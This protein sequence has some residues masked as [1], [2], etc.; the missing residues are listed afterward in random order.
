MYTEKSNFYTESV[1]EIKEEIQDKEEE[2]GKNKSEKK[3]KKEESTKADNKPKK[4]D[5]PK[6]EKSDN[7]TTETPEAKKERKLE[8]KEVKLNEFESLFK[9][10]SGTIVLVCKSCEADDK[11]KVSLYTY[12]Y[13]DSSKSYTKF[14]SFETTPIAEKLGDENLKI[15]PSAAAVNPI[16]KD[17]YILNSTGLQF[18]MIL[19][20]A[21]EFKEVYNVDPV[22]YKQPEGM[23]LTPAGDLIISNE[24]HKEGS[25]QLLIMNNKKNN[26]K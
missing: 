10:D 4:E 25:A 9:T 16:T 22:I 23:T 17:L 2:K 24:S 14:M 26:S 6:K 21:G 5:K 11:K 7:A 15:K 12:N 18:L 19:S 8:K 13:K 1:S 20:S 3:N